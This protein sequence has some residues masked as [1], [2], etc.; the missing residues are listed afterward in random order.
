MSTPFTAAALRGAVDLSGLKKRT[1]SSGSTA[2]SAGPA[3]GD[4]APGGA[5]IAVTDATFQQAVAT[6]TSVAAVLVLYSSAIQESVDFVDVVRS[7]ADGKGGRLQVMAADIDSELAIRQA[8]QVQSVPVVLGLVK[9]RP[10]PLF[11]GVYSREEVAGVFD[12]LVELATQQGVTG[13]VSIPESGDTSPAD[14]PV[15]V[16]HE[17][18]FAAIEAGDLD[19]ARTA[20]ESALAED[21]GDDDARLGLAQVAL[22]QRT[23]G[24]DLQQ[25]RAAAAADPRDV[26][27][28]LRVAD[29]DVLGGH[30]DD[31]FT[32]LVDLVRVTSGPD[33]ERVRTH[34]I[35]LFDVVG[36]ADDRVRRARTALMS[37]LF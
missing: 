26:E 8:F 4:A 10:V 35:G 32:R 13:S 29:L 19:A 27:A 12:Q 28:V 31:A 37:A 15:S 30:I 34:L 36:P 7:A 9:A 17:A 6:T 24:V 22:L 18:A 23:Q 1:T 16:H 14:E 2:T 25:A 3:H 33:R 11:G 21:P 5:V 20:Y